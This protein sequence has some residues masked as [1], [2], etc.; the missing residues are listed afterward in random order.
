ML[1]CDYMLIKAGGGCFWSCIWVTRCAFWTEVSGAILRYGY[2][3]QT[4]FCFI[5]QFREEFLMF[6]LKLPSH[7]AHFCILGGVRMIVSTPPGILC[8]NTSATYFRVCPFLL[9]KTVKYLHLLVL[10][11][12]SVRK[13]TSCL[14]SSHMAA[15]DRVEVVGGHGWRRTGPGPN[16]SG[17][18]WVANLW[19]HI[20]RLP[21]LQFLPYQPLHLLPVGVCVTSQTLV[22]TA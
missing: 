7:S 13:W 11:S 3:F 6:L 9:R 1:K 19:A 10:K 21:S 5:Q 20:V 14:R 12:V 22:L 17:G 16:R 4:L 8:L 18:L 2:S 15:C